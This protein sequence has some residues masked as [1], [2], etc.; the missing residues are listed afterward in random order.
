MKAQN[1]IK[2]LLHIL[3]LIGLCLIV[4]PIHAD[5]MYLWLDG[6][7]MRSLAIQ[8]HQGMGFFYYGMNIFK[9]LGD[10]SFPL[11]VNLIP[12]SWF[13][14]FLEPGLSYS[15][16][17][18]TTFAVQYFIASYLLCRVFQFPKNTSLISAWVI[19]LFV[20]PLLPTF[21]PFYQ[22]VA[23]SPYVI[24]FLFFCNLLIYC[25]F[26]IGRQSLIP[27]ILL[28]CAALITVL[29]L[30]IVNALGV[31]IVV[32]FFIFFGCALI[33][34]SKSRFEIFSKIIFS[35]VAIIVLACLHYF[36]FLLGLFMYSVPFFFPSILHTNFTLSSIS[37]LFSVAYPAGRYISGLGIIGMFTTLFIGT[38]ELKKY[39][40]AV[41]S[42]VLI[43]YAFGI[44]LITFP[45]WYHGPQ[46]LY[47]EYMLWPVYTAFAIMLIPYSIRL[48]KWLLKK[49]NISFVQWNPFGIS[50]HIKQYA[51]HVCK[52]KYIFP[53]LI[54]SVLIINFIFASQEP[55][56]VF[57]YPPVNPPP[58]IQ[59]LIKDV[60]IK[61]DGVFKGYTA[62]FY[63]KVSPTHFS[64]WFTQAYF[65]SV[66]L[67]RKLG[68]TYRMV[69]LWFFNIPTLSEYSP[70]L[71]PALFALAHH[72]LSRPIDHEMRNVLLLT[73]VNVPLLQALGVRYIIANEPIHFP[74]TRFIVA[75]PIDS[76]Y[77]SLYLYQILNTNIA[78]FSP[79]KFLILEDVDVFRNKINR[80]EV[81]FR[82]T[83]Y[84]TTEVPFKMTTLK[85][86][87][88]F[89]IRDGIRLVANTI[90]I[91]SVLLP[92]LYSHCL[93]LTFNGVKPKVIRLQRAN[94]AETLLI[95]SKH[96]DVNITYRYGLLQYAGCRLEDKRSLEK[97]LQPQN[98]LSLLEGE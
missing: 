69:G 36:Q 94:L 93:H 65:D 64:D 54:V 55:K 48:F 56:V 17:V 95:F 7:Y 63:P 22:I 38:K 97:I 29:Y 47:F 53:T 19:T 14:L 77:G 98:R 46:P 4:L 84:V 8:Q 2:L 10:I 66:V 3:V 25:F 73:Q 92:I 21:F 39:A 12:A 89:R 81:D 51:M 43:L 40:I 1:F 24:N 87:T 82:K 50:Q 42:F 6:S 72:T 27:S 86:A 68:Y 35:I 33:F 62:A 5:R 78:T 37:I 31:F 85:N 49:F 13:D 23:I 32:P 88:M 80:G 76:K 75:D 83:A 90:G 16:A 67:L 15:I 57:S 41:L 28:S 74:D 60:A 91:S 45:N 58:I 61:Q 52:A 18:Y 26:H 79:Q 71:S 44:V 34:F 9:G 70:I 30:V 20:M 11:L 96:I 59:H